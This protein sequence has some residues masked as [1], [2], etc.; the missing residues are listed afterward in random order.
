[1]TCKNLYEELVEDC[2]LKLGRELT[3]EEDDF[4]KWMEQQQT[5]SLYKNVKTS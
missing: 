2:R 3:P 5:E 4:V 1:M